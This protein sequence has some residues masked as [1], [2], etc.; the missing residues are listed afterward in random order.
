[1]I[2]RSL[3]SG[4]SSPS[5]SSI[6]KLNLLPGVSAAFPEFGIGGKGPDPR[7]LVD[8]E[9]GKLATDRVG[10]FVS[11][12]EAQRVDDEQRNTLA[13]LEVF[14]FLGEELV[15]VFSPTKGEPASIWS[16]TR[17]AEV[18]EVLEISRFGQRGT[19]PISVA[20]AGCS[21]GSPASGSPEMMREDSVVNLP[22]PSSTSP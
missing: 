11:E 16:T 6:L 1:V 8:F 7:A 4:T 21:S 3:R 12:V 2:L 14:L 15:G 9:L 20:V 13:A 17:V 22:I 19:E 10:E 18:S 5:W